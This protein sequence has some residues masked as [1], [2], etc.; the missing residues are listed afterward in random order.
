MRMAN[1]GSVPKESTRKI[2]E[3]NPG[4]LYGLA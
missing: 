2:L 1:D 4:I 3:T